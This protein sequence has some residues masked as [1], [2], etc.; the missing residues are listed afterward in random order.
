VWLLRETPQD[1]IGIEG[2]IPLDGSDVWRR[3]P[4]PDPL[5][6]V[7]TQ[8][9]RALEAR[10]IR[11]GGEVR[12]IRDPRT[13][14]VFREAVSPSP[15]GEPALR[16]LASLESPPLFEILR[17]INKESNN[18]LAETVGKTLGR[19]VSGDGSFS[20]G[21]AA[22]KRFLVEE[23]GVSPEDVVVRDG[24]GLSEANQATAEVFVRTLAYLF[25]SPYW[26][27]FLATLPEAGVRRELG[28]MYR[29]P[30]ARNLRA[31]TG[32]MD[33]VSALSGIVRTRTGERI[34]FS[35]LSNEVRSEY[36]AKRAED[37][38]GIRL[39]SLTRSL[40]D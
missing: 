8:L 3:L 10:G 14:R 33:G 6:F 36:R 5:S 38:L 7:G 29:S 34:L 13:S 35:F 19:T 26:E 18:F 9:R 37:Q 4:V 25:A 31:K 32:T 28:R 24:S 2:Q 21:G 1:P 30:A 16:I 17:V 12:I 20:G 15:S 23:V 39:A 22:I 27:P 11:A 40:Q